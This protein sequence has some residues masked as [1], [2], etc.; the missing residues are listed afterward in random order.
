M[1]KQKKVK[2]GYSLTQEAY[3]ALGDMV[4]GYKGYGDFISTLIIAERD[5]RYERELLTTLASI[6]ERLSN[7]ETR[8]RSLERAQSAR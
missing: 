2:T 5:K 3:E 1:S 8:L 6:E 7:F 4:E